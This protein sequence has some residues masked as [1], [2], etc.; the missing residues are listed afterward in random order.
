MGFGHEMPYLSTDFPGNNKAK[1]LHI[2]TAVDCKP[3][4]NWPFFQPKKAIDGVQLS[5]FPDFSH[6]FNKL[7]DFSMTTMK[8]I[9]FPTDL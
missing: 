6:T 3:L 5:K 1:F 9:N 4:K 2:L 8:E 7:P